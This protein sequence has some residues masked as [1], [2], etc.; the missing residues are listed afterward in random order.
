M[1]ARS[2]VYLPIFIAV[3][4]TSAVVFGGLSARADDSTATGAA[5][6]PP[7]AE[8]QVAVID[9]GQVFR[10]HGGFAE[11]MEQMKKELVDVEE[12]FRK[13]AQQIKV[14]Q[15]GLKAFKTQTEEHL[16]LEEE[17][18]TRLSSQKVQMAR[19]KRRFMQQEADIYAE[20]YKQIQQAI[21]E[22][23]RGHGIRL[24]LRFNS[25]PIDSS[26]ANSVMKGVNRNVVFQD[27]IDITAEIQRRLSEKDDG[28]EPSS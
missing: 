18:T 15:E 12:R 28:S 4:V 21:A 7:D 22:H 16:K 6:Q 26:D 24:V 23:A 3:S 13:D 20:I 14:L 27:G 25:S 1:M 19:E 5:S 9:V 10:N 2:I 11:K 8:T 17:I